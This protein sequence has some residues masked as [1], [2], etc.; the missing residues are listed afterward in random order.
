MRT[1]LFLGF[2]FL[3]NSGFSQLDGYV[4]KADGTDNSDITIRVIDVY[5]GNNVYSTSIGSDGYYSLSLGAGNYQVYFLALGYEKTYL[6]NGDTINPSL[7][8]TL[9]TTTLKS[10]NYREVSG[11]I[12][13]TFYS[14]TVY[15]IIQDVTIDLNNT[16][17]IQPGTK[18]RFLGSKSMHIDGNLIASGTNEKPILF[19]SFEENPKIELWSSIYFNSNVNSISKF[20][21]CKIQF[22]NRINAYNRNLEFNY[23]SIYNLIIIDL[24]SIESPNLKGNYFYHLTDGVKISNF[25]NHQLVSDNTF[26]NSAYGIHA[27][28]SNNVSIVNNSFI[29]CTKGIIVEATTIKDLLIANNLFRNGEECIEF[30]VDNVKIYNNIFYKYNKSIVGNGKSV[31]KNNIFQE[32]DSSSIIQVTNSIADT[33]KFR[34]NNN[35]FWNNN[36]NYIVSGN[37]ITEI[38][39]AKKIRTNTNGDSCDAHFNLQDK[40]LYIDTIDFKPDINSIV[41]DAGD[42]INVDYDFNWLP[43]NTDGNGDK[44]SYPDIGPYEFKGDTVT[45]ESIDT[46]IFIVQG[47]ITAGNSIIPD[48]VVLLAQKI[49]N[50]FI[51]MRKTTSDALGMYKFQK[52]PAGNYLVYAINNPME[53]INYLPTYFVQKTKWDS[54]YT[55]NVTG[56]VLNAD[57]NLMPYIYAAKGTSFI[58]GYIYRNSKNAI[59]DSIFNTQ[60]FSFQNKNNIAENR[61]ISVFLKKNDTIVQWRLTDE[62]GYY[63]FDSIDAGN[64]SVEI[65]FIG[66]NSQARNIAVEAN[67]NYSENID[68]SENKYPELEDSQFEI[69]PNPANSQVTIKPNFDFENILL[70]IFTIK[71][72]KVATAKTIDINIENLNKGIYFIKISANNFQQVSKLVVF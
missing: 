66:L 69:Y 59:E 6:Q 62:T 37:T 36:L 21:Y 24:S 50:E 26:I 53:N 14:D 8:D 28:N 47:K 25:N 3:T 55:I 52:L 49:N 42:T 9:E 67:N 40:P 23:N 11:S 58:D 45:E 57:V 46:N 41:I 12:N 15:Y 39:V 33:S 61:N 27:N 54:A 34:I 32:N 22:G 72:E 56:E 4:I 71:G 65:E 1:L 29:N 20:E 17:T 30:Y 38:P 5:S 60:W 2:L 51:T 35:L 16:L 13:G 19:Q 48:A 10:E 63:K 18:I 64:Y 31:I 70:E 43:R 44:L 7:I 68:I